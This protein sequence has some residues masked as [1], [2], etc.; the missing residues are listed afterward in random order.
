MLRIKR[1]ITEMK[2]AFDGLNWSLYKI[3][4][5]LKSNSQIKTERRDG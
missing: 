3:I 2:I 5:S 4:I 1:T